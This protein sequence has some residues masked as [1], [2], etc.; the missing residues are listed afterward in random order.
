MRRLIC[1]SLILLVG[2]R[3]ADFSPIDPAPIEVWQPNVCLEDL[4]PI[5][6]PIDQDFIVEG[7]VVANDSTGNFYKQIIIVDRHQSAAL[8]VGIGYYDSFSQFPEGSVVALRLEGLVLKK[9]D[10]LLTAGYPSIAPDTLPTPISSVALA[11]HHLNLQGER[12]VLPDVERRFDELRS[13]DIGRQFVFTEVYFDS[14]VGVYAGEHVLRRVPR[15][16]STVLYTSPYATFASD[17]VPSSVFDLKAIV[18]SHQG[19]LQLKTR[20]KI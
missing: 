10:G 19:K 11:L 18:M 7:V 15:D 6:T 9:V 4:E 12:V 5:D 14:P 20:N 13:S 17:A 16:T 1:L 8:A 2:C 3:Y